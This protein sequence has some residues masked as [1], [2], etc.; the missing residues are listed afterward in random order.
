MRRVIN[1]TYISLDGVIE[2]PQNW[3]S[4]GSFSD[5]GTKIQTELLAA[6]DAVLMGRRTYDAFAAVWPARSGD[7]YS[8]R[9]NSMTKYVVSATLTDPQWTNTTVISGSDDPVAEI[10]RLKQEPGQDIVQYGFGRLSYALMEAGLLDELRLWVHPF[11]VGRAE[12]QDLL[13]RPSLPTILALA[14]T[15]PLPSGTVILTY[16]TRESSS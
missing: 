3:P 12:S 7:P 14:D 10:A 13:F 9:I 1:S 6:C 8:A 4:L 16:R 11:F 5:E 15:H 2:N